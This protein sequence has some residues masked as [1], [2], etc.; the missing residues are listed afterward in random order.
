MEGFKEE[1][2]WT[3]PTVTN[4]N[5]GTVKPEAE[6]TREEHEAPLANDKAL[7]AIFS[8]VDISAFKLINTCTMAKTT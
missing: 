3:A 8:V 6:Y 5:V 4:N 7:N 1:A 2:R